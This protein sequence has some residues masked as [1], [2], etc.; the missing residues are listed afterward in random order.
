V[1][2]LEQLAMASAKPLSGADHPDVQPCSGSP[3][4]PAVFFALLRPGDTVMGWRCC[5]WATVCP[6]GVG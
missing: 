4:N 1:N 2:P 6:G 3:A 5:A